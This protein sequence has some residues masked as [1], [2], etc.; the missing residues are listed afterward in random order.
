MIGCIV[1]LLV[2]DSGVVAASTSFIYIFI[3]I[4]IM[5]INILVFKE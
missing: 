5:I 1:T 4:Y 2:N 3:P